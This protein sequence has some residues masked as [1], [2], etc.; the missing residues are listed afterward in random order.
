MKK[1]RFSHCSI[2]FRSFWKKVAI[3]KSYINSGIFTFSQENGKIS[4]IKEFYK[5]GPDF[6]DVIVNEIYNASNLYLLDTLWQR[7]SNLHNTSMK[8]VT[9]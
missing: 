8:A 2:F 5:P 9:S 3:S 1:L 4:S 6:E 7:R